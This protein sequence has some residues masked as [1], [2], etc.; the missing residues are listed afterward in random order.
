MGQEAL[1]ADAYPSL[2]VVP[3]AH[4]NTLRVASGL[5]DPDVVK[6]IFNFKKKGN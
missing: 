6:S 4:R 5:L 1:G 3:G 2:Q